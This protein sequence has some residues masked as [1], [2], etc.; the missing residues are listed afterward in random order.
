VVIGNQWNDPGSYRI[1]EQ[2]QLGSRRFE[3]NKDF[4]DVITMLKIWGIPFDILRLDQQ[5]LQI[6]RFL[7]GTAEPNYSCCIWMA[8]PDCLEGFSANYKTVRRA[9]EEY[10]ISLI[11]L[12]D[13]I[14]V[15]E[16]S[17]ILGM[18]YQGVSDQP[19]RS[20]KAA[21]KIFREHFITTGAVGKV[22]NAETQS[23]LR[24]VRGS[25]SHSAGH[26]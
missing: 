9:V 5:R 25:V 18:D 23:E 15:P 7:N 3:S 13:H 2:T 26:K 8:N 19:S 6:N 14:A 4:R 16:L 22:V 20:T 1:D 11:A 17:D 12:F 10:G 21:L 24:V